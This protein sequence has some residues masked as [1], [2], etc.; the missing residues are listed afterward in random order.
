MHES[1]ILFLFIN[2]FCNVLTKTE[3][4]N[5]AFVSLQYKNTNQY[6][7]K[8]HNKIRGK[9]TNF[10]ENIFLKIFVTRP[11]PTQNNKS[12]PNPTAA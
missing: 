6:Y 9:I 8:F 7:A 10:S 1:K 3:Y 12:G 11:D 2:F 5:T 4:F